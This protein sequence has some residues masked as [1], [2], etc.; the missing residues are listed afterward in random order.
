[1][2]EKDEKQKAEQRRAKR[3]AYLAYLAKR[4]PELHKAGVPGRRARDQADEEY[5]A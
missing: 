5:R 3:D 1:M 2:D 4:I